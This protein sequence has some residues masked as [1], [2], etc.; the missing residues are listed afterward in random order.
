MPH[1]I[2]DAILRPKLSEINTN[3]ANPTVAPKNDIEFAYSLI[4]RF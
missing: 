1:A 4:I 3:T 2:P